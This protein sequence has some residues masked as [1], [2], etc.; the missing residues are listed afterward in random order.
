M[1]TDLFGLDRFENETL[2]RNIDRC[3]RN[4]MLA[5]LGEILHHSKEELPVRGLPQLGSWW[6]VCPKSSVVGS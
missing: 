5:V 3:V 4:I 1:F 2:V 6:V